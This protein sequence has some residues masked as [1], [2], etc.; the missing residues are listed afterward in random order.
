MSN[1]SLLK[2]VLILSFILSILIDQASAFGPQKYDCCINYTRK[3]VPIGFIKGYM[4]QSSLKVCRIDA[5][6]FVTV[7]DKKVCASSKDDWVKSAM[8][9][10]SYR[11]KQL[12]KKSPDGNTKTAIPGNL[13][14]IVRPAAP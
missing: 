8:R 9:R 7:Q 12:S 13:T 6:V 14:A 10:L 2:Y 1:R 11:L 5:I 3:P 4:E